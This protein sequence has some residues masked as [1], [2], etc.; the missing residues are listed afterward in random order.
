MNQDSIVHMHLFTVHAKVVP[1]IP[2]ALQQRV[3]MSAR[4]GIVTMI[5]N[6]FNQ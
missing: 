6:D 3:G 1:V 5:V 4:E 2:R